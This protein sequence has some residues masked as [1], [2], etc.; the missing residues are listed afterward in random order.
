MENVYKA[1]SVILPYYFDTLSLGSTDAHDI[2]VVTYGTVDGNDDVQSLWDS[3]ITD[4]GITDGL[5][6]LI[7][8]ALIVNIAVKVR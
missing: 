8:I 7:L 6:L 4:F 3:D 1:P 2:A 5:L